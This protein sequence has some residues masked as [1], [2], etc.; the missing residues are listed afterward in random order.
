M[1]HHAEPKLFFW[2]MHMFELFE[3]ELSS[4][5]KIKIKAII[6]S[7][8]KRKLIL[9]QL[10]PVQPSPAQRA[11]LRR[12][13]GGL[14]L[15]VSVFS[16]A[17]SLP[18]SLCPVGSAC[19]RRAPLDRVPY[20]SLSRGTTPSVSRPARPRILSWPATLP[21]QNRPLPRN[22][23][24]HGAC[25]RGQATPTLTM[26]RPRCPSARWRPH[27]PLP[28]FTQAL[29][30][31]CSALAACARRRPAPTV[32]AAQPTGS[33][34]KPPRAPS[35]GKEPIPVL[36]FPYPRLVVANLASLEFIHASSPHLARWLADSAS[37]RAP[38]LVLSTLLPSPELVWALVHPI[39]P[40]RGRDSLP[41]FPRSAQSF[42]SAVL[43]PWSRSR[44]RNP[45]SEFVGSFSPVLANSGDLGA[46]VACT[47]PSSG[48]FTAVGRSGAARCRQPLALDLNRPISIARSE[49]PDTVSSTRPPLGPIS[50]SPTPPGAG[51]D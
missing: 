23:P 25:P 16:P 22:R 5:E 43:S 42:P 26:T 45:T 44:V 29:S 10:S 40:P 9:A 11:R 4:L 6:N 38:A 20:P 3:F 1:L 32:L 39:L 33:C 2:L 28:H 8:K 19:R 49:S 51:P 48:D 34:A 37:H 36:G 14:H 18:S 21:C 17:R 50:R 13:T 41:E 35:W 31:S 24:A 47:L 46:H 7:E 27:A 30:L 12:V 15:S